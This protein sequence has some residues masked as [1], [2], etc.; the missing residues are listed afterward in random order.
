MSDYV[1]VVYDEARTPRTEYP[2]QMA[3]YLFTRFH[4]YKG[5][6]LLEIGC[7]RGEFLNAFQQLGMS[8]YGVDLS[9]YSF[10]HL[11]DIQVAKVD[12]SQDVLPFENNSFDVVYHKSLIEHL[13]S[14]DHLMKETYRVLK[15]EG[16]VIILTP[17]WV[18]T[19]KVFYEDYTHSRPYTVTAVSDLLKVYDFKK[20]ES[21]LFYQL[22]ILWRY[23][24]LKIISLFLQMFLSTP[25]ARYLTKVTGLKFFRW[26]VEL[27]VLGTGEKRSQ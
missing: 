8:C 12:I 26:S 19:M 3:S 21:E 23:P 4:L 27:M 9:E 14:P 17:D 18:S 10:C 11:K 13:Y 16:R 20:I 22:P 6:K 7:G 2:F 5:Q 24:K 25:A 15:P 1:G